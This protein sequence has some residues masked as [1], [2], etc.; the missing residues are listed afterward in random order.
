MRAVMRTC[1]LPAYGLAAALM[2]VLALAACNGGGDS[3]GPGP[4]LPYAKV[5]I[6]NPESLTVRT[7]SIHLTGSVPCDTCPPD[8]WGASC[9]I[10]KP[11][12]PPSITNVTW[13]NRTT[14]SSGSANHYIAATRILTGPP[15]PSG[16]WLLYRHEWD[17]NVPLMLGENLIEVTASGAGWDP[18]TESITITR[19]VGIVGDLKA[20]SGKQQ[21][22]LSWNPVSDATS[23]NIYWSTSRD[24]SKATGTMIAGVNSSYTHTS[25]VDGE[26][27]Y[28]IVTAVVFGVESESS[29]IVAATPGWV[30]ESV[31]NSSFPVIQDLS[32][33]ADSVGNA[34]I[35]YSSSIDLIGSDRISRSY[36]ATNATG[37]WAPLLVH[38]R[39]SPSRN[40]P[41]ADIALDSQNTVHVSFLDSGS[42]A[43]AIYASGTWVI[44]NVDIGY[45]GGALAL[46]PAGNSHIG[47]FGNGGL[48]YAT[49]IS[50]SWTSSLVVG[51]TRSC[52]NNGE[53]SLG[54]DAAG[55]AH[56]A[57]RGNNNSL[58]Y[59][60]NQGGAWTV[61]VVDQ[62]ATMVG[63]SLAV[64][65]SGR[66]HIVY[67][68][69][70]TSQLNYAQNVSG[71]W[72]IETIESGDNY[73]SEL[74]APSLSLDATGNAHVSYYACHSPINYPCAYGELRY[75]SNAS[76][77]WH[78]ATLD[79][80]VP[81]YD[82]DIALD[83][84]GK[85]HIS[86]N[87]YYEGLRYATNK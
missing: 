58:M 37:A 3:G 14:G 30:A 79:T 6:N 76:G 65:T 20:A 1:L 72:T 24:V 59:A 31:V 56:I 68:N 25:L 52:L 66:V 73:F 51:P 34:H 2:L 27:Y 28:Y 80:G 82:T 4:H 15:F 44:R 74:S 84:Q 16:C 23:Y 35:H 22:T 77:T 49:N 75:A 69:Y 9:P 8:E 62:A 42:L 78:I 83:S 86:Y 45:C 29:S 47:Y 60:T 61:S 43:Y 41:N 26:T 70:I 46:D 11:A 48:R 19:V 18:G 36:Y 50:G 71:T 12:P 67:I 64:D 5:S 13:R 10:E 40:L 17:A 53:V 81:R 7:D 87:M 54:V 85:A 33:A 55:N 21:V 38:E 32:I 39:S 63:T 57:H